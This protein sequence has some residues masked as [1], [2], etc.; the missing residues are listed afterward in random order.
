MADENFSGSVQKALLHLGEQVLEART[1]ASV[2]VDLAGDDLKAP[3][4]PFLMMRQ[5]DRIDQA[6]E[7]LS[8]QIYADRKGASE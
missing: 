4:W 8:S 3:E 7:A 6:F 2:S 5:I 1:W